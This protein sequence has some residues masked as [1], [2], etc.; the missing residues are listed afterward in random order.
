MVNTYA[1][2]HYSG[3]WSHLW[4]AGV[5]EC[6]PWCSIVGATVTVHQFFC[7][8]HWSKDTRDIV[9]KHCEAK[10]K[11]LTL[12]FDILTPKSIEV[13][14]GLWSAHVWNIIIVCKNVQR[15]CTFM[16]SLNA[17]LSIHVLQK[18]WTIPAK[19]SGQQ[20]GL[21]IYFHILPHPQT[22]WHPLERPRLCIHS[23]GRGLSLSC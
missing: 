3:T 23:V 14:L 12:T 6:P 15:S 21:Y 17:W 4:F 19:V 18:I 22:R 7:I 10:S 5:R 9:W 20:D 8:L 16:P 1:N 2:Y 13:L 11:N